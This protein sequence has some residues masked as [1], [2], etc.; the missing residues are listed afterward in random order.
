M[1]GPVVEN[2]LLIEFPAEYVPHTL[3]ALESRKNRVLWISDEDYTQGLQGINR[4]QWSLLMDAL[5]ALLE[6]QDRI[7]RLVDSIFNGTVYLVQTASTPTTPAIVTPAIPDA[8]PADVGELPGLRRQLLNLQ[9]ETP[10]GW[11]GLGGRPATIADV[12]MALRAGTEGDIERINTTLDT[13]VGAGSTATIFNTIR[14]LLTDTASL[15]AEGGLLG[16]VIAASMAQA[17]MAGLDAAQRDAINAKLDRLI[18]QIGVLPAPAPSA[19]VAG[20]LGAIREHLTPID[21]EP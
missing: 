6:R 17:A 10:G 4:A 3:S 18:E 20:E 13:L 11:F 7:Y 19:T 12:V 8:P 14:G 16:V 2:T 21:E 1:Q 5:P 9:G 15:G